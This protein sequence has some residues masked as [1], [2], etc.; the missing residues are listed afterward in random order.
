MK[1]IAKMQLCALGVLVVIVLSV[2]C[3][4]SCYEPSVVFK[5]TRDT[6]MVSDTVTVHDTVRVR[7]PVAKD[8]MQVRTE[9][10]YLKVSAEPTLTEKDDHL[11]DANKMMDSVQVEIPIEQ[12]IYEDSLYRAWVSGY[13]AKLDSI[14][15][16]MRTT[17]ITN[18]QTITI[19]KYPRWGVGVM[20][21]VGF[22]LKNKNAEPFVGVGVYYRLF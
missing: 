6:V 10:G 20:G 11:I 12:T 21:G 15:L 16:R 2:I 17:T 5:E 18:T 14:E 22:G 3:V 9:V 1:D 13:H 4:R 7:E 19:K 8:S